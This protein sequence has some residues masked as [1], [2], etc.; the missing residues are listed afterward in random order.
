MA[1]NATYHRI[2]YLDLVSKSK[3]LL[4]TVAFLADTDG[5]C[6]VGL[7][8]IASTHGNKTNKGTIRTNIN[9]LISLGYLSEVDSPTNKRVFAINYDKIIRETRGVKVEA[10]KTTMPLK[11]ETNTT[12]NLIDRVIAL[13]I[14]KSY[15]D[16]REA[17][18]LRDLFTSYIGRVPTEVEFS[19]TKR[20]TSDSWQMIFER[21][22]DLSDIIHLDKYLARC[23]IN[24]NRI[25]S[26]HKPNV[27]QEGI[28][29]WYNND[30]IDS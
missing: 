1:R 14:D 9:D 2:W 30:F 16:T 12:S 10:P 7:S 11:K 29:R 23:V 25:E 18:K 3:Y 22:R 21:R 19:I 5:I 24:E 4:L 8:E 27:K 15:N 13:P 26:K 20:L 6:S 28:E 17:N